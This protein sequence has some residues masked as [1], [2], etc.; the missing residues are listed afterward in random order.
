MRYIGSKTKLLD[1]IDEELTKFLEKSDKGVFCDMFA[2]TGGVG[3]H[4]QNRYKIIANDNLYFSYVLNRAKLCSNKCNFNNLKFDPFDFFNS[5]DTSSYESGYCYQTF[6]P[7][8]GGR[9]YF[10]DENAK[11]IDYIRDNIEEWYLSK[12]ISI[13]EHD[14]LLG[15]LIESISKVS[16][17]AGVYAAY[18]HIWDSRA[19]KKMNFIKV[20]SE[21]SPC[22]DNLVLN[23]DCNEAINKING[24]IL[25]LDPPY[26][27]TQYISQYHVLE[28]IAKNDKP[29]HHGVGAHRDNGNQISNWSKRNKV[30]VELYKLIDN[31]KFSHIVMSYSDAGLMSKEYIEAV[32]KRL[33]GN[34][35][36]FVKISFSKYKN[37]RSVNREFRENLAK[38]H[39]EWLFLGSKCKPL[40]ISPLNYIGG[41]YDILDFILPKFP[42]NIDTFFDVFGGGGTVVI[43]ADAHK[44]VYNDINFNVV[45]L[46][47]YIATHE[48][49][50]MYDYIRK[51]I[52]KYGLEKGNKENYIAFR[53][54]YNSISISQ[55]HPL[56]LYLLICFGFEHQIRF[57]SKMEFNNPCG[58]SGFND[59]MLE[60]LISFSIESSK[61]NIN[62]FSKDFLD[63][64]SIIT[65]SDFVYCDPPYLLTC[66]AYN[67]GKRG[68]NGWDKIQQ[69]SLFSFLNRLNRRGVKFALSYVLEHDGSKNNDFQQWIEENKYNLFINSRP[70]KRNRQDRVETLVTNYEVN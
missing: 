61:K 12:K 66:G 41:K 1:L 70:T 25:Y 29:I 39:Y 13:D 15:C 6:A 35:Y 65:S 55:R 18:L 16:N 17:V 21:N 7:T 26:T 40:F 5:I 24:D 28:T 67:D 3:D 2:G 57:N 52:K 53:T 44:Y 64:E 54:Q 60:K 68:F 32:F 27:P 45:N 42:K 8:M 56:D 38:E 23:M 33:C 9:Q 20:E 11:K 47:T 59:E 63:Y 43:N 62:Y 48:P 19:T 69:E 22:F 31:A 30:P 46:L 10:S 51:T 50:S 49:S 4:F 36:K 58:N 34:T 37:T 14:Y